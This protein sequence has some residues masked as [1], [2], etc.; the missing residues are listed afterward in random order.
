MLEARTVAVD[1]GAA[2]TPGR[3]AAKARTM[4]TANY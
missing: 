3:V 2:L 4:F 1:P